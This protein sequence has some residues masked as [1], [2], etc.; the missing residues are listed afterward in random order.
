MG[1]VRSGQGPVMDGCCGQPKCKF[2]YFFGLQ[3]TFFW[4]PSPIS[5][6][7]PEIFL[8]FRHLKMAIFAP[9]PGPWGSN[10]WVTG[11]SRGSRGVVAKS[12]S[13][14]W[15]KGVQMGQPNK[16]ERVELRGVCVEEDK[17]GG[18]ECSGPPVTLPGAGFGE[19]SA[20]VHFRDFFLAK[21]KEK[22]LRKMLQTSKKSP[23][24]RREKMGCAKCHTPTENKLFLGGWG[25]LGGQMWE[26][27][28]K[29]FDESI[30]FFIPYPP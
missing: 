2:L 29:Q 13:P 4:V 10:I 27:G 1:G 15:E 24:S 25:F 30:S 26:R 28:G 22:C 23:N 17:K 8:P 6:D 12:P 16:A 14:K 18:G 9:V 11:G 5:G 20:L 3:R 21:I 19:G 7:P